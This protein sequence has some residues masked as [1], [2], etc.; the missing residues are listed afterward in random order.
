MEPWPAP[1]RWIHGYD[2]RALHSIPPVLGLLC[3]DGGHERFCGD[4]YTLPSL[5]QWQNH[6]LNAT[7]TD[8]WETN[9]RV[10]RLATHKG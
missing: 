8:L 5:L 2:I 7:I 1:L 4:C 10:L 3:W 6:L 9:S